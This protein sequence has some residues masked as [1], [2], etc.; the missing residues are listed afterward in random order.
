[1][2]KKR[3]LLILFMIMTIVVS[4]TSGFGESVSN[5]EWPLGL[6]MSGEDVR[7]SYSLENNF[8]FDLDSET[9]DP[10]SGYS[11]FEMEA[12]K[13]Y[14][15]G[16]LYLKPQFSLYYG[17]D[18]R[19]P[20]LELKEGYLDVYLDK[21]DFRFGK[22]R[23]NWGKSSGL[24]ITNVV[25]PQDLTTYPTIDFEDRFKNI[26]MVK[27]DYYQGMDTW[28]GVWIPEF[29]PISISDEVFKTQLEKIK[30]ALPE[31]ISKKF[32]PSK[33]EIKKE[34]IDS[35]LDENELEEG[36][37]GFDLE[38]TEYALQYSSMGTEL[39]YEIMGGYLWDDHPTLHLDLDIDIKPPQTNQPSQTSTDPWGKISDKITPSITRKHHRLSL[40]GGS[41]STTMGDFIL[42]GETLFTHGKRFN[43][44][45]EINKKE[46]P[47]TPLKNPE[48]VKK[49]LGS[50]ADS[51]VVEKNQLEWM[52]GAEYSVDYLIDLLK[53]QIDQDFILDYE[54]D[55]ITD[56]YTTKMT[57]LAQGQYMRND[58]TA[59]ANL[60]Y[61]LNHESLM[62]K[63]QLD[64]NYDSSTNFVV[65]LDQILE[66]G[67]GL[68]STLNRDAVYIQAEYLF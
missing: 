24:V 50:L 56:E 55:I 39:D 52:F 6:L 23:V 43:R 7:E 21:T 49:F 2:K 51:F 30:G 1:M 5:P 60:I 54:D 17:S 29:E 35:S 32:D 67:G 34:G 63:F 22:Q 4:G 10:F 45:I 19:D 53:F 42:R 66:E 47:E 37:L 16:S 26:Y 20:E 33:V 18:S 12:E 57:F 3:T 38:E 46:I 58:L 59:T 44:Q 48:K 41:A 15:F 11:T 27:M 40:V 28:E 31:E 9:E 8:I 64:Y 36:E 25:N 65:G 14:D 61:D 62:S 13:S 68:A